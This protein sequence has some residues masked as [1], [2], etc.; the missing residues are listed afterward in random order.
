MR[1][2]TQVT[3]KENDMTKARIDGVELKIS[4]REPLLAGTV[5][6]NKISLSFS[7]EWAIFTKQIDFTFQ[8]QKMQIHSCYQLEKAPH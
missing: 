7:D 3:G 8:I 2:T 5:G 1:P 4:E 6:L